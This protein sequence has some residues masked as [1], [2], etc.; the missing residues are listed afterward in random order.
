MFRILLEVACPKH[1]LE[2]F[3]IKVVKKYNIPSKDI[4][5]CLRRKPKPGGISRLYVGRNVTEEEAKRFVVDYLSKE[6]TWKI[7]LTMKLLK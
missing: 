5:P 6:G 4:I 1:G 2:R 3:S 7:V